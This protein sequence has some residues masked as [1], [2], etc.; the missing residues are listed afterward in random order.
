MLKGNEDMNSWIYSAHYYCH[1]FVNK[2]C[3]DSVF[4]TQ[5]TD[6]VQ[7]QIKVSLHNFLVRFFILKDYLHAVGKNTLL[8]VGL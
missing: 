2:L 5:N 4:E 6:E 1:T 3:V 7:N 8:V